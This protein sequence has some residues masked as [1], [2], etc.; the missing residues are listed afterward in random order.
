MS[1][2]EAKRVAQKH[3]CPPPTHPP[4]PP[5]HPHAAFLASVEAKGEALRSGLRTALAGNPHVQEV[6]GVGL[7]CGIQLDQA[8]AR[9]GGW[10][11]G[12]GLQPPARLAGE[13]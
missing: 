6:R 2:H 1:R 9:M 12:G 7:I 10:V 4:H 11:G 13:A 3:P 5:T 8:R